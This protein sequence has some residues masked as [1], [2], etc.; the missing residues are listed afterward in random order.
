M[1]GIWADRSLLGYHLDAEY[2]RQPKAAESRD[3]RAKPKPPISD[4]KL[5][6]DG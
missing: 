6:I 4:L 1:K 3:R 5:Q 2:A